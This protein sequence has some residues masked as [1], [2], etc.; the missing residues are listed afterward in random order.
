MVDELLF[1]VEIFGY[2]VLPTLVALDLLH[3]LYSILDL[4]PLTQ[5]LVSE[6]AKEVYI[7]G[8][9]FIVGGPHAVEE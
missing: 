2:V 9:E 4:P 8:F 6:R 7:V 5:V 1:K 3:S